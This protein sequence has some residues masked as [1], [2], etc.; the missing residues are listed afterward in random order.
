MA[1]RNLSQIVTAH[2]QLEGA[3]FAVYRP[4]PSTSLE[5]LDPFLMLDE[6]EPTDYHELTTG[7][8]AAL[9]AVG[10]LDLKWMG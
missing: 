6:K 2:R 9:Q 10:W 7:Y 5:M 8:P 4:F 1:H 3:G